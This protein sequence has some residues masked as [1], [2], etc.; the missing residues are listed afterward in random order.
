[1]RYRGI[2]CQEAIFPIVTTPETLAQEVSQ[3][4]SPIDE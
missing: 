4:L 2:N 1:M 3:Q